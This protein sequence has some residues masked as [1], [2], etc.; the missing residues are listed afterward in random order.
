MGHVFVPISFISKYFLKTWSY[1]RGSREAELFYKNFLKTWSY[2]RG[3]RDAEL[4]GRTVVGHVMQD[5]FTSTFWKPGRTV[6]G[7]VI[8][9][10][11]FY[12]PSTFWKPGRTVVGH[13]MQNY[14][15]SLN[16]LFSVNKNQIALSRQ[17]KSYISKYKT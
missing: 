6:V 16:I 5:Y 4:F 15:P 13:V 8:H 3:P 12:F 11:Q 17:T 10:Y 14:F 7:H 1:G 9:T 2:G